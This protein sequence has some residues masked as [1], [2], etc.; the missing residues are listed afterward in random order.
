MNKTFH[1]P[2]LFI[3][4]VLIQV[5]IFNN[6]LFLGYVNPY[7]YL[8]FVFLYPLQTNRFPFL[9]LAFLLGLCVDLFTNS[10]GVHAFATLF[11]AYLRLFFVKNIFKK[12][13]SDFLLFSLRE[14]SFRKVFNYISILT[15][16]HHFILFSL[17]NFSFGNLSYVLT[18][19]L[20][21]SIFTLVLYFTGTF[22]F[23]KGA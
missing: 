20:L 14:E 7:V 1:T 16:I 3:S 22:I 4:L 5:L 9:S 15:V 6:I 10:G 21:S 23:R 2:F 19:T 18:N 11:V 17:T 13:T 12:D 8:T